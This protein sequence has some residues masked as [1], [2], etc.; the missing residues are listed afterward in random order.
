MNS[1]LVVVI[2]L[3]RRPT[4]ILP[5]VRDRQPTGEDNRLLKTKNP[6]VKDQATDCPEIKQPTGRED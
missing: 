5:S 2:K 6:T 3:L 1:L 4:C